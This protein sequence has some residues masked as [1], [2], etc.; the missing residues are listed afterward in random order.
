M[1]S[2][3]ILAAGQSRRM[4]K[5]KANLP[6]GDT[7]VLGHILLI[8]EKG[9]IDESVVVVGEVPVHLVQKGLYHPVHFIHNPRAAQSGMITSLQVGLCSLSPEC[10][11]ALVT[12]GDQPQI[13]ADVVSALLKRYQLT[14]CSLLVPSF[15]NRRGHPWLIERSMWD[16]VIGLDPEKTMRDFLNSHSGDISYM[17]TESA[18]IIQDMD[19]PA[20]YERFR[21]N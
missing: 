10:C 5:P 8:L 1:I 3:V 7:T 12:L 18:S 2:A 15:Q 19:T 14:N 11:A 13:E 21:P 17:E 4:G 9:G 16:A 20:D 6:W